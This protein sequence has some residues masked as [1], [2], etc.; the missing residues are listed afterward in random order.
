LIRRRFER[1]PPE[2][3]QQ[4]KDGIQ[5]PVQSRYERTFENSYKTRGQARHTDPVF[6]IHLRKVK[7]KHKFFLRANIVGRWV[8]V[9][10]AI[11][12]VI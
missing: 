2:N 4:Y 5:L 10:K 9:G 7:V 6:V 3:S 11:V 8:T 12:T 1:G